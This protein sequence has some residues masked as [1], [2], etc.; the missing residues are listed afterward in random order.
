M[1]RIEEFKLEGKDFMYID[2]SGLMSNDEFLKLTGI[3]ESLM[4]KY[5]E[6]SLYTI[7]N[8]ENIRFGPGSKEMIAKY[9]ESNKPYVKY[10]VVIGM[11]GIKKA[12]VNVAFKISGRDNIH[13]AFT[14]DKAIEWLLRQD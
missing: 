3:V 8:I 1:E 13:F 6:H 14:K 2:L 10:G 11:D 7:T 4:A 9:L 12:I 5:P